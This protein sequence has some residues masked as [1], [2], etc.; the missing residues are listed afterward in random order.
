MSEDPNATRIS[1][2]FGE[3]PEM[4][5]NGEDKK[6]NRNVIIA[7]AGV[8]ILCCCCSSVLGLWSLYSNGFFNTLF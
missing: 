8:V 4:D 6:N 1:G 5:T 2:G 7:V 3:E